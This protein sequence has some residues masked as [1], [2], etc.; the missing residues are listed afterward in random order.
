[1]QDKCSYSTK[2]QTWSKLRD[3][4]AN[5]NHQNQN[6]SM[7]ENASNSGGSKMHI[8]VVHKR[9]RQKKTITYN[10]QGNAGCFN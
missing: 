10:I 3:F 1:M 2:V 5:A 6:H 4:H 7:Y 8:F 9:D